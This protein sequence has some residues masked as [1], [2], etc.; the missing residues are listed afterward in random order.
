MNL[1]YEDYHLYNKF[2]RKMFEDLTEEEK[3]QLKYIIK[4]QYYEIKTNLGKKRHTR[5]TPTYL[6]YLDEYN[7]SWDNT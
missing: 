2:K 7:N 1:Y 5:D 3:S 6:N 4:N